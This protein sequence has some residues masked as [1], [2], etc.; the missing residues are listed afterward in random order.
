MTDFFQDI[1]YAFRTLSRAPGFTAAA[2]ITLALGIGA[3][4][5]IFTALDRLILR[6]LP[7]PH[8]E[9][10]QLIV[11]DR[12]PGGINYNL[13]YPAFADLRE[14]ASMFA[15]VLA[16]SPAPVTLTSATNPERVEAGAVSAGY[17]TTLD[18]PLAL[19]RDIRADEDRPGAASD[20]VVLSHDFWR[21]RLNGN[22]AIVGQTIGL[23]GRPF[24]VIGVAPAGFTGLTRGLDERLWIPLALAGRTIAPDFATRRGMSW[25]NVMGRLAPHVSHEGAMSALAAFDRGQVEQRLSDSTSHTRLLPAG[26]GF[27]W[28]VG[29][30]REPLK[31]LMA[32]VALVLLIACANVAS[33]VLARASTRRREIAIRVSLGAGAGRLFRQL[34]TESA[35]LA[36]AGGIAGLGLAV[37][38]SEVM[39]A[40]RTGWGTPIA[41]AT[42][43]D[44]RVI[45]FAAIATVF[46]VLVFGLVPALQVARSDVTSGLKDGGTTRRP[47]RRVGARD[48]LV[49]AQ[50]ALSLVLLAGAALFL[51]TLVGLMRVDPGFDPEGVVLAGL[52]LEPRGYNLDRRR[53]FY[54]RLED[55][56]AA[57]PV[58]VASF[59]LTI[60]PNPGGRNFGGVR[61]EGYTPAPNE[62]V[63]FDVNDVGP[64]YFETLRIPLLLGR[65]FDQR[66][67]AG[68]PLTIIVNEAIV[69]RY[70]R[71]GDPL[72]RRIRL[73]TDSTAP[74]AEIVGVV[75]DGKYRGLRERDELMAYMPGLADAPWSS[76]IL[77]RSAAAPS[78]VIALLREEVRA[79][80]PE[81]PLL[82][83]STMA[84]HLA[85]AMSRERLLAA[86]ATAMGVLALALGSIGLF[87][88]LSYAV[89]RRTREFGIRLAVGAK[90][91]DVVGL[92]IREGLGRAGVGLLIGA[93]AA[94]VVTRL[95]RSMLYDVSPGDPLSFLA[96]VAVLG[97]VALAACLVP[98]RRAATIEPMTALRTE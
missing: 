28:N 16:H 26:H 70:F 46:T 27:T 82:A 8:P 69:R 1:R 20:V 74:S 60:T 53:D 29:E 52:D 61:I 33:L 40:L 92:V 65:A 42:G 68:A 47:G 7:V 36:A 96:A 93:V 81:L 14:R 35:V 15:G 10:L 98:A 87:G 67:R 34:L 12:G 32:G 48:T 95:F 24:T 76:S 9:Q 86:L 84:E 31:V 6:S 38:L 3:N 72:G 79:L 88:L 75:R 13:S 18:V 41:G 73:S 4:T 55:R 66:D 64:R 85:G 59:A 71:N 51:R 50:V 39:P 58:G 37:W 89:A 19:G 83:P 77:V 94:L 54:G 97:V 57:L 5:A 91:A 45:A 17:F 30:Y 62:G 25:L 90:P 21:R 23:N 56:L 22:R 78:R 2:V 80:D 43:V 49:I 63:G 11:T 44:G